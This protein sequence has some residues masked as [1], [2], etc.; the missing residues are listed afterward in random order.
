MPEKARALRDLLNNDPDVIVID[1]TLS[2]EASI[3]LMAACDAV[4]SL[5]RSEGLGLLVAEAMVMGRPVIAT[6]YSA[7][8]ELVTPNTGFPV[9]FRLIPV[10]EGQYPFHSGQHWADADVDHAAWLMRRILAG[11]SDV[12]RRVTAAQRHVRENYGPGVVG[13]SQRRRLRMIQHLG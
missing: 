8:T 12:E 3:G 10:E 7:T 13:R 11:G 9:N 4:V 5:H 2:R 6:D 1:Q